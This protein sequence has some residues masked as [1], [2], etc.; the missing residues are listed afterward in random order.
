LSDAPASAGASASRV[1]TRPANEPRRRLRRVAKIA[2][3][4]AGAWLFIAS[5]CLVAGFLYARAGLHHVQRATRE[6]APEDLVVGDKLAPLRAARNDF[7]YAQRLTGLPFVRVLSPVPF[8]GRQVRAAHTLGTAAHEVLDAGVDAVERSQQGI[9]GFKRGGEARVDGMRLMAS[10][11]RDSRRRVADIDLGSG[12]GLVGPLADARA[13]FRHRLPD[14]ERALG[15]LGTAANGFADFLDGPR[16]YL[17][18][19]A[20]NN[21]MRVGSGALLSTTVLMT[22]HG[23]LAL[24]S[25]VPTAKMRLGPRRAEQVPMTPDQAALW[26]WLAPNDEWRNLGASPRFPTT[27]TLATRMFGV[28]NPTV[29]VDGVLALDPVA[30]EHLVDATGPVQV[31]RK[32]LSGDALL[33]YILVGQYQGADVFDTR[34]NARRDALG[35]LAHD[36]IAQIDKGKWDTHNFIA[37]LRAAARGR[38]VL[39][40][41]KHPSEMKAWK[42][43]EIDGS[44]GRDS[45]VVGLHNRG[46]NKLDTFMLVHNKLHTTRVAD[47]WDVAVDVT[48]GNTTPTGLPRYV[49]GPYPK[50]VGGGRNVY[51][52]MVVLYAP[53][54]TD[55]IQVTRTYGTGSPLVV[56][57]G[58]DGPSRVIAVQVKLRRNEL[59]RLH[60]TFH[61][62]K[63]AKQ[64]V[65]E[66]SARYPSETWEYDAGR[67]TGPVIWADTE[68]QTVPLR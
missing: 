37:G 31:G 1:R 52:G 60:F 11:A 44:V 46:G 63:S 2:L 58:R 8:V 28:L 39:A 6:L 30:L 34:Q 35:T 51:Q 26:G 56:A 5:V 21:E 24:M 20:N 4:V 36:A 47:G 62:P 65:V 61:L 25:Q 43:A 68:A 64:L 67:I 7:S 59:D 13:E 18:L 45:L 29:N 14:L 15:D 3:L 66:P 38:H 57:A 54:R 22:Y 42:I 10:I 48:L 12:S 33:R 27:A 53:G 41:S 17:L 23:D 19:A 49:A 32:P 55:G 16:F 9:A 50:A 40:W